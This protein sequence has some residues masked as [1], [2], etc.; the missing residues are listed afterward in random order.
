MI[1][2]D[3]PEQGAAERKTTEQLRI[4]NLAQGTSRGMVGNEIMTL[5]SVVQRCHNWATDIHVTS[6]R[7]TFKK[8]AVNIPI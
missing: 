2:H 4:K 8:S 5:S 6:L 1:H 3:D 7:T